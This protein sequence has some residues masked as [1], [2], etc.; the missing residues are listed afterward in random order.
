MGFNPN[1]G[2]SFTRVFNENS[3]AGIMAELYTHDVNGPLLLHIEYSGWHLT[4]ISISSTH[5]AFPLLVI[6][7]L[8]NTD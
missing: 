4:A 7:V 1:I 8:S 2:W 3:I 6:T 5:M